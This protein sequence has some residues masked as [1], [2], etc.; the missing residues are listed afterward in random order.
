[1]SQDDYPLI[2]C[3]IRC[4][5][6]EGCHMISNYLLCLRKSVSR[7][8]KKILG[9]NR[10]IRFVDYI[11]I[12]SSFFSDALRFGRYSTRRGT[13]EAGRY[14]SA[15]NLQSMMIMTSHAL[16][17]AFSL[18]EIRLGFGADKIRC[19]TE[20]LKFHRELGLCEEALA[21]VKSTSVLYSYV[22]YHRQQAY[23]LGKTEE[24][25]LPWIN[26]RNEGLCYNEL[27]R[28]D[29]V[30]KA[31]GDFSECANSRWSVRD[32]SEKIVSD[33]IIWECV[34]IAKKTPSVCNRQAWHV[35]AV[36]SQ[37]IKKA[38][39]DL[40]DGNRGFGDYI[41]YVLI[42]TVNQRAFI[43]ANERNQAFVEGG[44][45]SMSLMYALHSKGL[46]SCSLN[47]M[48]FP[49]DD[50]KLRKLLGMGDSESII[51]YLSVGHLKEHFFVAGSAR[52]ETE[53]FITYL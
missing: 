27:R 37:E 4:V 35:Y 30:N 5:V 29:I 52:K 18:P 8:L 3:D 14:S 44:L 1:M 40:Q 13:L 38:A 53:K 15:D 16:E 7:I 50:K 6:E 33:E 10:Y 25:I 46:G 22:M 23:D 31:A 43:G 9:E 24:I 19:L 26:E 45:F 48:R 17:K 49:S 21:Y 2:F 11:L 36:R 47:W 51:M 20:M 32:Y 34:D 28:S 41:P 42:I 39:V 12:F